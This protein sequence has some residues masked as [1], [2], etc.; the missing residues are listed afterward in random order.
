MKLES[1][2]DVL[3][4]I[5]KNHDREFHLLLGNGF[6]MAYD[7]TIFSYNALHGFIE[8]LDDDELIY[9]LQRN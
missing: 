1:F 9:N 2:D 7:P 4:S 5:G 3:S 8:K 6:S